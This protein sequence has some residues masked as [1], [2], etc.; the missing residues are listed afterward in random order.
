M[1]RKKATQK[2]R[3][4]AKKK[5]APKKK[6]V[7]RKAA[8]KKA[9]PKKKAV[10]RK[11]AKKKAAPKK[12]AVKR[13]AAKKKAA[14]KKKAVKRKAAKKK[15]APKKK[16]VKRK[17]AKKKAAPKK[18]AAKKKAGGRIGPRKGQ[19]GARRKKSVAG[20]AHA[21]KDRAA[22]RRVSTHETTTTQVPADSP[23]TSAATDTAE[24]LTET[25]TRRPDV[26]YGRGGGDEQV[27]V[28]IDTH[29]LKPAEQVERL[30]A[31]EQSRLDEILNRY[32]RSDASLLAILQDIQTVNN[33]LPRPWMEALCSELGIPRT[34]LYRLAT[35][36]KSLS[37]EP[38]GKYICQVC[39]GTTCHVRGAQRLVDKIE[40]EL[41]LEAGETSEDML[42]TMETVGCVGACALGPLVVINGEY[43]GNLT[44]D[45]LGRLIKRIKKA[46]GKAQ[47]KD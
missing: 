40:L 26:E 19:A 21:K 31:E 28:G 3:K 22:A 45:K 12:K 27:T 4:A 29:P 6:A 11:A 9:A 13:K 46:E 14:P 8:K 35:F 38:R 25:R 34:R 2:K 43:H 37:L 33:Y 36:F 20:A 47:D 24:R 41:D 18:K 16:A 42:W 5:A 44:G 17:A 10:K 30:T 23:A 39:I 7:K 1:V 15:A 32:D